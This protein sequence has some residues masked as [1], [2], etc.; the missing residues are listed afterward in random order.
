MADWVAVMSARRVSRV[1]WVLVWWIVSASM[2]DR[3]S[4]VS[5]ASR[6]RLVLW[7]DR[8]VARVS[9]ARVLSFVSSVECAIF[10]VAVLAFGVSFL[11]GGE[12]E[13]GDVLH[14]PLVSAIRERNSFRSARRCARREV[15]YVSNLRVNFDMCFWRESK[16]MVID[17]RGSDDDDGVV[18]VV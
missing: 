6:A 3:R 17:G 15:M 8:W 11:F 12:G 5:A 2:E 7:D 16:F 1:C 13:R 10:W 9:R 14:V 4:L 18:V